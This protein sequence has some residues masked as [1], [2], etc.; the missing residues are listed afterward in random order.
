MKTCP[1]QWKWEKGSCTWWEVCSPLHVC[2]ASSSFV[3]WWQ[4]W[5][6]FLPRQKAPLST[7][8]RHFP[9]TPSGGTRWMNISWSS[10]SHL[11]NFG[12]QIHTSSWIAASW[13]RSAQLRHLSPAPSTLC[14]R[15]SMGDTTAW[16][17]ARAGSHERLVCVCT[18]RPAVRAPVGAHQS[19]VSA[20]GVVGETERK[21]RGWD[22]GMEWQLGL[23][24]DNG[25]ILGEVE[26]ISFFLRTEGD[27]W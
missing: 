15:G 11:S 9:S 25:D 20:V 1:Y 18:G 13:I 12:W 8:V 14:G 21:W 4:P 10:N 24:Y 17:G 7:K 6:L 19:E 22:M 26:L 23:C 2:S 16:L 27:W 5:H 3:P